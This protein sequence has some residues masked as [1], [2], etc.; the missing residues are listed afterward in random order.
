MYLGTGRLLLGSHRGRLMLPEQPRIALH[1][2]AQG[3]GLLAQPVPFS[4]QLLVRRP[5]RCMRLGDL[6]QLGLHLARTGTLRG[7]R[8]RQA[9][10]LCLRG[11]ELRHRGRSRF[12]RVAG[13]CLGGDQLLLQGGHCIEQGGGFRLGFCSLHC[14]LLE[15]C[16]TVQDLLGQGLQVGLELG[17][18]CVCCCQVGLEVL[19][20][21]M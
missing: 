3:G 12:L 17:R 6:R 14:C 9:G 1:G 13:L 8:S 7:E 4:R 21:S 18:G 2:V 20:R 19:L 15:A 10:D 11:G 5:I 16:V